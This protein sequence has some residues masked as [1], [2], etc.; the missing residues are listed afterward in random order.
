[1]QVRSYL[2]NFVLALSSV[3]QEASAVADQLE[4]AGNCASEAMGSNMADMPHQLRQLACQLSSTLA[5]VDAAT[6][7]LMEASAVLREQVL[8]NAEALARLVWQRWQLPGEHAAARLELA[9]AAATRCCAYLRCSQLEAVG[10]PAA[11]QGKGS[12]RCGR[13][14]V[15]WYCGTNCSHADWRA[16]HSKVCKK[17]EA[18]QTQQQG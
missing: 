16:G 1:M 6:P 15:V 7:L 13:C 4:Q 5:S 8:R 2:T 10:G 9:Q 14:R 17:L 12:K 18:L 11:G 3:H